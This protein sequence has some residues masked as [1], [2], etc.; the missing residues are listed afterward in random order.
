MSREPTV[1][2][3]EQQV[4]RRRVKRD[5]LP[6]TEPSPSRRRRSQ[7]QDSPTHVRQHH[8]PQRQLVVANVPTSQQQ[9]QTN[10]NIYMQQRRLDVRPLDYHGHDRWFETTNELGGGGVAAIGLRHLASPNDPF[11]KEMY[12]L[13]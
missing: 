10:A 12:V 5:F 6:D 1:T 9:Q 8:H 4:A 3:M 2:W 13:Q 11:F 7:L